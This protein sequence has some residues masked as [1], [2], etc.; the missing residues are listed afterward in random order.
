MLSSAQAKLCGVGTNLTCFLCLSH[1]FPN[2]TNLIWSKFQLVKGQY[3]TLMYGI[4]VFGNGAYI[5]TTSVIFKTKLAIMS[6]KYRIL[7]QQVVIP[8]NL[9]IL[10]D[11]YPL[12]CKSLYQTNCSLR[13]RSFKGSLN[14]ILQMM[15]TDRFLQM[16]SQQAADN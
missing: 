9:M 12:I 8:N 7:S 10:L 1:S 6:Q 13:N 3:Y 16:Q 5:Y 2:Y 15:K 4:A 11:H 14:S